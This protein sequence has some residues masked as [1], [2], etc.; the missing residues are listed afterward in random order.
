MNPLSDNLL[1]TFEIT[2]L[3]VAYIALA[4]L[5]LG[6]NLYSSW[7]WIVKSLC[8]L[9]MIAL[10]WITFQ[11]WP[12]LLGWPAERDLPT[13]FYLYAVAVEE[14]DRIYLWGS[15]LE[16]GMG[17]S[18]PRSYAVVYSPTLHDRVDKASRKLRKGLPVIGQVNV[19]NVSADESDTLEQIQANDQDITF[20]DAPQALV[21][22]K[23]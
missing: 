20:I 23:N 4:T 18:V 12:G 3:T 5:L 8:N 2:G 22:G 17:R 16:E 7:S 1:P 10:C 11:S 15:D 21:P 19:G 6:L 14:P 9:L 13:L